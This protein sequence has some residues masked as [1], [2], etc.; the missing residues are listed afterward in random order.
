MACFNNQHFSIMLIR[1]LVEL[2]NSEVEE[3]R[4]ISRLL[5]GHP[6]A[7]PTN[8]SE[9]EFIFFTESS[10]HTYYSGTSLTSYLVK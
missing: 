1:T 4:P 5:I 6:T 8:S 10:S 9:M 3:Y 2:L 7:S